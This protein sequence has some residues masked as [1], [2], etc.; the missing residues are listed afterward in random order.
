M[1]PFKPSLSTPL[2]NTFNAIAILPPVLAGKKH[3]PV[4]R[5]HTPAVFTAE[6]W[7]F[8]RQFHWPFS[9]EYPASGNAAI[10]PNRMSMLSDSRH[11]LQVCFEC[12]PIASSRIL[13]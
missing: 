5:S 4:A 13:A 9:P 2:R 1:L 11:L 7:P 3:L 10:Y 12:D 8:S 6:R